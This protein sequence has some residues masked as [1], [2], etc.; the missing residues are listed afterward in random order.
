MLVLIRHSTALFVAPNGDGGISGMFQNVSIMFW[1]VFLYP[2]KQQQGR[3]L[4][5]R[6]SSIKKMM[7]VD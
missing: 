1:C 7:R 2:N 6:G 4:V 5:G 3:D